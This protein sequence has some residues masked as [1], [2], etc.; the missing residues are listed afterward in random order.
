MRL[1]R[2]LLV[3]ALI[4]LT[5]CE[6]KAHDP[7]P[8]ATPAAA[9][10]GLAAAK[11]DAPTPT[12]IPSAG[13]A[14]PAPAADPWAK[15]PPPKDPLPHPLFWSIEKDGKTT[16]VLGT[17]HMGVDAESR[18]P[19]VV[20][21]DLDA[22]PTFA[23]ETDI[24]DASLMDSFKRTSGTLH[25]ELGPEYWKKLEA[26]LTPAVARGV[27]NM[28]AMVPATVLALRGLK[29][30]APMDGIL[31]ERAKREKKTIVFLEPA[32]LQADLLMKWMDARALK[33]MLDDPDGTARQGELLDAYVAGDADKMQALSD[34]ERDTAIKHGYTAA[35]YNA[36][37]EDMLYK[38]NASWI[39]E[40]DKLTHDG[41]GF[42]AVG[43]MHLLGKRSVLDLLAQRGYTVTR[44]TP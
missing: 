5:A 24:S 25:E 8:A 3:A 13:A 20:W 21:K 38:R 37:M 32:K 40:I 41:G 36:E 42:V 30:T 29:Q 17:I 34:G 2:R 6:A 7:A 16:Y 19:E 1:D 22:A 35:E 43:A 18:L 14:A 31:V 11:S 9:P 4:A 39:D 23:M 26:A 27:D 44:I 28:K 15:A 12:P 33:E 10:A